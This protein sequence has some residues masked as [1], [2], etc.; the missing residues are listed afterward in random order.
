MPTLYKFTTFLCL[1]S[2]AVCPDRYQFLATVLAERDLT[3]KS[4]EWGVETGEL[5]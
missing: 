2:L 5:F 4:R 1:R 3:E